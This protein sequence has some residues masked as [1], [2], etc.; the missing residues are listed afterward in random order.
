MEDDSQV[1]MRAGMGRIELDRF[2]E[3]LYKDHST[4]QSVERVDLLRPAPLRGVC[5]CVCVCVCG[6]GGGIGR[7]NP[8]LL[9][10]TPIGSV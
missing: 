10:K 6:G 9:R 8:R 5:V 2:L 3:A 4:R 7:G 1:Q